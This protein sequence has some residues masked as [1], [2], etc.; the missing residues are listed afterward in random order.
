MSGRFRFERVLTV[1]EILGAFIRTHS[2]SILSLL[3][4][5]I[6][7]KRWDA[8]YR[9][10]ASMKLLTCAECDLGPLGW[11]EVGGKEFWLAAA[12]VAYRQ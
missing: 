2:S 7:R 8:D 3:L 11:N 4:F 9:T 1:H 10:G 5:L 6:D 12:R